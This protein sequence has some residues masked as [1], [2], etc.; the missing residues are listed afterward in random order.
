[1]LWLHQSLDTKPE[2]EGDAG[3]GGAQL[4]PCRASLLVGVQDAPLSA[5]EQAPFPILPVSMILS[6]A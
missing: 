3:A 2:P 1:M 6:Q 4:P 5:S